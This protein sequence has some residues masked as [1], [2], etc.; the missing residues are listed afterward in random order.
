MLYNDTSQGMRMTNMPS[1]SFEQPMSKHTTI[2][3]SNDNLRQITNNDVWMNQ[4]EPMSITD[5][6]NIQVSDTFFYNVIADWI[7]IPDVPDIAKT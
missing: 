4:Y 7:D 3:A 6:M 5:D 1:N 2:I